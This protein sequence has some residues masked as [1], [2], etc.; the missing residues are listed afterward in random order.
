[1]N[2]PI[3]TTNENTRANESNRAAKDGKANTKHWDV[4]KVESGLEE[5]GHF[6]FKEKVKSG[7]DEDV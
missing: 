1:M 2:I 5:A 3:N 7:I 6:C 4:A